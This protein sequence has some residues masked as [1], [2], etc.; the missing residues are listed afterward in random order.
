MLSWS[1]RA[2]TPR[3]PSATGIKKENQRSYTS[4]TRWSATYLYLRYNIMWHPLTSWLTSNTYI[5]REK[6]IACLVV[7][8]SLFFDTFVHSPRLRRSIV[9]TY[10][11]II[12]I[13]QSGL[14]NCRRYNATLLS[15]IINVPFPCAKSWGLRSRFWMHSTKGENGFSVFLLVHICWCLPRD[16]SGLL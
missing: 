3:S 2:T 12:Y 14:R 10:G 11:R 7:I 15:R 9:V 4:F 1:R 8:M 6:I 5:I 13:K 16:S